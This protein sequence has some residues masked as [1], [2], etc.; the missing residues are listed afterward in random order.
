MVGGDEEGNKMDSVYGSRTQAAVPR[1][2][3]STAGALQALWRRSKR[4]QAATDGNGS[5]QR[6]GMRPPLLSWARSRPAHVVYDLHRDMA[7]PLVVPQA[8][9]IEFVHLHPLLAARPLHIERRL[10]LPVGAAPAR[11]AAPDE[12]EVLP[13]RLLAAAPAK[14]LCGTI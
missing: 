9:V 11:Q 1:V 14:V 2:Y 3:D 7:G 6:Q 4:Q 10:S 5:G 12:G 13:E 8:F